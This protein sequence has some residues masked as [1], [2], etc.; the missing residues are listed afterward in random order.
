MKTAPDILSLIGNT[1]LLRL[2]R[3]AEECHAEI[4]GKLEFFNP[5][6]SVKD[7]IALAMIEGG[8]TTGRIKKDTVIIEPTSG[9]TGIGLAMVC[10]VKGYRL[11]LVMP[12]NMSIERR[13]IL[14]SFGA[15]VELTPASEGMLGS[16]KKAEELLSRFDSSFMPMQFTNEANPDIH[17]K[18]TAEEIW[19]DTDGKIDIFISGVGTGG[20]ITGVAEALKQKNPRIEAIAVEPAGSAVLSGSK[21]SPHKIQGIG[22]G[23][24]PA[25][26]NKNIVDRIITVT[27]QDAVETAK[28]LIRHEGIFCGISSGANA[29]A[30]RQE[31]LNPGNKGK[32]IVFMVCDT[33][34]R[35]LSTE[36]FKSE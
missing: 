12:D 17:R 5:A 22:A 27:D 13:N 20:T 23:F 29:W 2:N 26:L 1:P 28:V 11:I 19:R 8:E 3:F 32:I 4:F 33:A 21:P 18:T 14:K 24:I 16:I 36:L 9:N 30:A 6:S 7:R 10:A 34:E 15:Q 31:G 35:Y 25:V